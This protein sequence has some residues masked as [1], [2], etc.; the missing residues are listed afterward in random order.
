MQEILSEYLSF[1]RPLDDLR[2]SPVDLRSLSRQVK[3]VL[4]ARSSD[5]GVDVRVT[6]DPATITGDAQRLR[7]M[8]LN[9]LGNA[10]EATPSEGTVEIDVRETAEGARLSVRDTGTGMDAETLDKLGQPFFSTKAEGT[11]LGVVIA[12]TTVRQHGGAIRYESRPGAG[13]TVTV[14]LPRDVSP[15]KGLAPS[16]AELSD[17]VAKPHENRTATK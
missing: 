7:G 9:L 1:T 5:A 17:V 13:T 8:L 4:E 16:Y 10:L 6:G 2:T 14:D 11:G 15:S 12:S 3:A